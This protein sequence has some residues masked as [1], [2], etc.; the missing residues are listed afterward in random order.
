V[1]LTAERPGTLPATR[2]TCSADPAVT[3]RDVGLRP[4]G[5]E[6]PLLLVVDAAYDPHLHARVLA[7][8]HAPA[9]WTV[10]FRWA[11]AG[12]GPRSPSGAR[13]RAPG[14]AWEH[15]PVRRPRHTPDPARETMTCP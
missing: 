4:A 6:G 12:V 7:L 9:A 1:P 2:L 15:A 8:P 3:F 11:R 5:P 10:A 13:A 14:R